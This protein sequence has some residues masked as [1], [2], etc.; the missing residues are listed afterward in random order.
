M[1]ALPMLQK[2]FGGD[3]RNFLGALMRFVQTDVRNSSLIKKM[4]MELRIG[5]REYCSS[6]VA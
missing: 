3:G 6:G 1:S 2:S 4:A 5:N